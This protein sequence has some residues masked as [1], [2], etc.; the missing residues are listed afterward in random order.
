MAVRVTSDVTEV[1][2]LVDN[3]NVRVSQLVAEAVMLP[4]SAN[5]RLAQLAVEVVMENI[6]VSSSARSQVIVII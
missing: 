6:A 5:V 3:A 4:A 1:V 2:M